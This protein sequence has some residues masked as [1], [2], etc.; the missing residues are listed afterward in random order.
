MKSVYDDWTDEELANEIF[1]RL[2]PY[3]ISEALELG[4]EAMIEMLVDRDGFTQEIRRTT[5]VLDDGAVF[6]C[7][8]G[9]NYF[10]QTEPM[11]FCCDDC[12]FI[13]E[14]VE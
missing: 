11:K 10:R 7:S 8:C 3:T 5:F 1:K 14:R 2:L 6:K 4:R 9:A 13:Y 12:G